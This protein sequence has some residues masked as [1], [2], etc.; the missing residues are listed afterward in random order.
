M[1]NSLAVRPLAVNLNWDRRQGDILAN[2][3]CLNLLEK[4]RTKRIVR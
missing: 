1:F 4:E 2:Y 3:L